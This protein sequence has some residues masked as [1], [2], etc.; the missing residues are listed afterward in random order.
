MR[1]KWLSIVMIILL[2]ATLAVGCGSPKKN[3][4]ANGETNPGTPS[5]DVGST[6]PASISIFSYALPEPYI[7]DSELEKLIESEINIQVK[8]E[9]VPTSEYD[10]KLNIKIAGNDLT[11]L[12]NIA[13]PNTPQY[14]QLVNQGLFFPLDEYLDRMPKLKNAFSP[15]IWDSIRSKTDGKIYGV[16]RC[17]GLRAQ[18][19][20]YRED[21]VD[22]LG[23]QPPK[24][25][26]EFVDMLRKIKESDLD[27]NGKKDTIPLTFDDMKISSAID[28]LPLFGASNGW[29]PAPGDPNRLEYGLIQDG[30]RD[31]F[32]FLRE[33]RQEGLLDADYGIGKKMGREKFIEGNVGSFV[34]KINFFRVPILA[35]IP[36]K[37]LDPIEHN[38][39]K[40][41]FQAQYN[42][43]MFI[44]A[45]PKSSKNVEAALKYLEF[46]LV[47][48]VDYFQY[49]IEGKTY[50]VVDGWKLPFAADKIAN[51]VGQP[52]SLVLV[53]PQ[54]LLESPQVWE[55][56]VPAEDAQYI[57]EMNNRHIV[58]T[59]YD[60]RDPAIVVPALVDKQEQLNAILQ[61][62]M[63][64]IIL[65]DKV[66][67]YKIWEETVA[68]WKKEGGDS[69]T[70]ELNQLQQ[71]KRTPN[72]VSLNF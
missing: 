46:M 2:T 26:D 34:G 40:W 49:G 28:F 30:A 59:V 19:I 12:V 38:G 51:D 47:D 41:S 50:E 37:I 29:V 33:L 52:N 66:D 69:A 68:R 20:N 10:T 18:T 53:H 15:E 8:Y 67:P 25:L 48:G 39:N 6:K 63:S 57:S 45:I 1:G 11:D 64:K 9:L 70:E 24:T 65:D 22:K 21:W 44:M 16:P 13:Y 56:F 55:K 58:N 54:A 35:G 5:A 3:E 14:V 17:C 61:E 60:H 32:I 43:I 62:G 31:A 42:Q 23:I 36:A 7:P 4:E 72:H 27:G 71:D